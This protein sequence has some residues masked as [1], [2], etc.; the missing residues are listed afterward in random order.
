MNEGLLLIGTVI[1]LCMLMDRF[2]KKIPVPSLVVFV[3][4]GMCFGENGPLHIV[5]ND[6]AAVNTVCA[7]CLVF[8]MFYGGFSTNLQAARPVVGQAVAMSTLGV[9][10][11]AG[12]VGAF[13]HFVLRMPWE[14]SLLTGAVISS[15]DAA[16]V[17][18]ILRS[19]K[20]AL[21]GHTDS[22]LELESGSNDPISYLLVM[23][24][25]SLMTGKAVSV[26]LLLAQQL[27]LGCGL[28]V[29]I[30]WAAVWLM[31]KNLFPFAQSR[32]VFLCGVMLLSY[33]APAILGGNG[34]LSSYL[35][36]IWLG[37]AP[38]PQK[39]YLVHF[40]DV[41]TDVSQVILF[42]LLG[43]LVTPAELPAVLLPAFAIM[44]FLTLCARPAV[45]AALLLPFRASWG[46]I[47]V[48]S[49]AGLRGSA[50]IVF[51]IVAVLS[52]ALPSHNL[53]NLVFCIV[54]LSLLLQG[55][56]LPWV[57]RKLCM[58]DPSA[59]IGKTFTDYQEESDASFIQIK[60]KASHPWCGQTVSALPLVEGMMVVMIARGAHT[61]VPHGD[62][63][64]QQGDLLVLAAHGFASHDGLS[65]REI[66][67]ARGDKRAHQP[68][69]RYPM[70]KGLVVLIKRGMQTIIPTGSTVLLPGDLLIVAE[71]E[72]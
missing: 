51:S 44:A 23:V 12:A 4:L 8:L 48:V 28:G 42:F 31:Q 29:C 35:C 52:G 25:I 63:T 3:I 71:S 9:I 22:L 2:L 45:S 50:S 20:L 72:N 55:T 34:Y 68:L 69:S 47:G 37:N 58:L 49:W 39:K 57:C 59:D 54:L 6:Y 70:H 32:T 24:A 62:T 67:I 26:P 38:I 41:V 61:I 17:F 1:F 66:F 65:L 14:Q 18:H 21:K 56:L 53:Y 36:G 11:T 33:A 30:A 10:L 64:L 46:Q 60:L 40:F 15:T 16:S 27:V 13:V 5:F 19:K 43:L 7:V